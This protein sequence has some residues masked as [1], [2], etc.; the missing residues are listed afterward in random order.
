MDGER[1][2]RNRLVQVVKIANTDPEGQKLAHKM[3]NGKLLVKIGSEF[4]FAIQVQDGKLTIADDPT[5]PK[6]ICAF[7]DSNSAWALLTKSLSPYVATV[8]QQL[9][10]QG[11]SPMNETFEKIWL[12]THERVSTMEQEEV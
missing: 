5:H 2:I 1:K 12:L 11:L 6:A 3:N 10:Q 4:E 8:H 7:S 9:N